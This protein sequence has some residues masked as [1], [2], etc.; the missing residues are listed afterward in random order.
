V[1]GVQFYFFGFRD[2]DPCHRDWTALMATGE[3]AS[4][5]PV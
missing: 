3:P 5:P 2:R 4:A 1:K